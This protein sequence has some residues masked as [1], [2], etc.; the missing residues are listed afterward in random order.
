MQ[1]SFLYAT[2]PLPPSDPHWV[3]DDPSGLA[4]AEPLRVRRLPLRGR[5]VRPATLVRAI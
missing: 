5:R 4:D 3:Y 2:P 1:F